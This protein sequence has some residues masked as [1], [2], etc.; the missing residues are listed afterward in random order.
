MEI[1]EGVKAEYFSVFI[2]VFFPGAL[3]AFDND[4]LQEMPYFSALRIYCAGIWHNAVVMS[5]IW[6][7]CECLSYSDG[8]SLSIFLL[9]P[10][11]VLSCRVAPLLE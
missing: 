6:I 7:I 8:H 11:S 4:L 9:K 1:S 3:V 2:A 5:N 10:S